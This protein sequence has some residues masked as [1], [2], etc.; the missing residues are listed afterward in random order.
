METDALWELWK[1]LTRFPTG[2]TGST[3][4]DLKRGLT[5]IKCAKLS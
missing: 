3:T 2:L 1:T 4:A 5:K